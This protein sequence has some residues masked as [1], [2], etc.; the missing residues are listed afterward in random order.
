MEAYCKADGCPAGTYDSYDSQLGICKCTGEPLDQNCNKSCRKK[1]E[2]FL[3]FHC[4]D[5]MS[6]DNV[7]VTLEGIEV[8]F[9]NGINDEILS[10]LSCENSI[11]ESSS[12]FILS[13]ESDGFKGLYNPDVGEISDIMTAANLVQT[14]GGRKRRQTVADYSFGSEFEVTQVCFQVHTLVCTI[15]QC[16]L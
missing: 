10:W 3:E 2:A 14:D 6:D 8:A 15:V 12:I 16:Y 13:S 11:A 9:E 4:P 1:N 7:H 5:P